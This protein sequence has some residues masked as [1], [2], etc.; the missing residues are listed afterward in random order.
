MEGSEIREIRTRIESSLIGK[1]VRLTRGRQM[2][3]VNRFVIGDSCEV[4]L[5]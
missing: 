5:V 1:N 3:A 4:S 2:P